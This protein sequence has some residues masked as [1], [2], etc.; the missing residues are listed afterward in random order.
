MEQRPGLLPSR[1][2]LAEFVVRVF[3]RD[4]ELS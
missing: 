1:Q 3:T 2:A 4:A